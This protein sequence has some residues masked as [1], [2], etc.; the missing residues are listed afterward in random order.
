MAVKQEA[1]IFG[2]VVAVIVIGLLGWWLSSIKDEWPLWQFLLLC[3]TGT[4]ILLLIGW[5][6]DKKDAARKGREKSGPS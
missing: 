6:V 2:A 5:R 3:V 1:A 4:A